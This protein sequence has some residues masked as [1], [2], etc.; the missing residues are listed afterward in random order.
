MKRLFRHVRNVVVAFFML[1]MLFVFAMFQG[2]F[3]SWFMFFS[4]LPIFIYQMSLSFYPIHRWHVTRTVT[5]SNV[6]SGDQLTVTIQMR[7]K[8]PFP[9]YYLVC[10]DILPATVHTMDHREEKYRHLHDPSPLNVNRVKKRIIFPWFRRKIDVTY[11]L[12]H[13]PRG[14]H[15]LQSIRIR[16]SDIF[17]FI[18]KEHMYDIPQTIVVYPMIRPIILPE[19]ISSIQHGG[20]ASEQI[21]HVKHTNVAVGTREYVPGDKFSWINWKQTAKQNEIMTK[22]F[23]QEKNTDSLLILDR[24]FYPNMNMLAFEAIVELTLSLIQAIH[25]Q[26]S[27]VGVLSIGDDVVHFPLRHDH[28]NGKFIRDHLASIRPRQAKPFSIQLEKELTTAY[29]HVVMM[30]LTTRINEHLKDVIQKV[31]QQTN[32]IIVYVVQSEKQMTHDD[33]KLIQQLRYNGISVCLLSEKELT[34]HPIEVNV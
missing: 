2:G 30:I 24:C 29:K 25:Q 34:K 28:M 5:P 4:F 13:I 19:R 7:R 21:M 1:G 20:S 6:Q 17:G 23:E 18:K 9:L 32:R 8:F 31:H 26:S 33:Q 15:M 16:T 27:Q 3:V 11:N 10:E 12:N 14:Q 22:E